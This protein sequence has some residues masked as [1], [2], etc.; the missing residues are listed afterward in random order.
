MRIRSGGTSK[1]RG[2]GRAAPGIAPIEAGQAGAGSTRLP[3][4]SYV[5]NTDLEMIKQ[6]W[7]EGYKILTEQGY[8][9]YSMAVADAKTAVTKQAS[10]T[11]DIKTKY[12]ALT[13]KQK[14]PYSEASY[15]I[16][17][18]WT[19]H[20]KYTPPVAGYDKVLLL[21]PKATDIPMTPGFYAYIETKSTVNDKTKDTTAKK[22]TYVYARLE[23]GS[24]VRVDKS[25]S[26]RVFPGVYRT[27][28]QT[29][30]R[31]LVTRAWSEKYSGGTGLT[32]EQKLG[33]TKLSK[34]KGV[35]YEQALGLVSASGYY[36]PDAI[37]QLPG[38]SGYGVYDPKTSDHPLHYHDRS[39]KR[40]D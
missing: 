17:A 25:T 21:S 34:E 39:G 24:L 5:L 6:Q 31:E 10:A 2:T 37:V 27:I 12:G 38:L 40:F 9:A 35:P 29:G 7:P 36:D 15:R 30:K 8:T 11:A 1:I 28:P 13:D 22:T 4:N 19:P 16:A 26:T 32:H 14:T 33:A 18:S 3:D 20:I 23:D